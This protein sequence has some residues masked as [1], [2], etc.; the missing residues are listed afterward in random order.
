M[1]QV[2]E[3]KSAYA[4]YCA[5]KGIVGI[6]VFV[7]KELADMVTA[8]RGNVKLTAYM[9]RV[10]AEAVNAAELTHADGT[11]WTFDMSKLDK[12]RNET[13]KDE[14]ARLKAELEALRKAA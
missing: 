4:T 6:G 2:Q 9:R 5:D 10:I 7:E 14:N 13:L 3:S 11:S 1:T 12:T 8:H